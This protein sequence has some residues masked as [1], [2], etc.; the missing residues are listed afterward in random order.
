MM[1]LIMVLIL[2]AD[3]RMAIEASE[4]NEYDDSDAEHNGHAD[5]DADPDSDVV[6]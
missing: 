6:C 4:E 1:V 2:M 3:E 5:R